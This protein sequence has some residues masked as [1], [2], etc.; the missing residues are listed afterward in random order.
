M[1]SYDKTYLDIDELAKKI[2]ERIKELEAQEKPEKTNQEVEVLDEY[3]NKEMEKNI[4]DLDDIIRQID[5]RIAEFEKEDKLKQEKE[6]NVE[7]LTNKV[8]K[9]LAKLDDMKEEDLGKTI[10]DL[11]EI[12]NAINE[13]IKK[14]EAKKKKKKAMKAKYC[15]LAR[16]KAKKN[17]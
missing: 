9:K 8:N 13:T 5:E 6:L 14:L 7:D 12:A 15:E 3:Y 17:K 11:S 10:Y 1:D 16:K 2:E 4:S